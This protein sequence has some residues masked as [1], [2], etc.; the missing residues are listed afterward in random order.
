MPITYLPVHGSRRRKGLLVKM[1]DNGTALVLD[2]A[3]RHFATCLADTVK[4]A[5][6]V[7]R[8]YQEG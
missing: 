1:N 3:T 6:D 7:R 8:G 4:E 5:T 2:T